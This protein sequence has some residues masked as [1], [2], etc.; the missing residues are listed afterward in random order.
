VQDEEEQNK[1]HGNAHIPN[2][3]TRGA[4]TM[5][6][7]FRIPHHRICAALNITKP[8]LYKHYARE[9]ENAE[10]IVDAEVLKG[11]M[12]LVK[13]GDS[14]TINRYM[15]RKFKFSDDTGGVASAL[16]SVV[17]IDNIPADQKIIDVPA[18]LPAVIDVE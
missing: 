10:T 2:E 4:V 11:W 1:K 15:E 12:K 8:T 17:V 3:G 13:A 18:P 14:L 6:S 5:L 7:A 16:P 9:L